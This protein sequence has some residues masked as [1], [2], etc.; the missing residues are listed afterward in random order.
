[1]RGLRTEWE[2]GERELVVES[3]SKDGIVK[4]KRGKRGGILVRQRV[5]KRL[6]PKESA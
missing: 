2:R 3:T 5:V 4:Y 6:I 1:M